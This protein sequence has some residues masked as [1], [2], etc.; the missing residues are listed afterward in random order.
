MSEQKLVVKIEY[1]EHK[2]E[3][4]GDFDAVT[5]Q[6]MNFLFNLSPALS[7]LSKIKL[8]IDFKQLVSDLHGIMKIAKEG[9]LLL[10][11]K[12][13]LT[14]PDLICLYLIGAYVGHK[15]GIFE[16]DSMTVDEISQYTGIKKN[17]VAVRLTELARSRI[18]SA[19]AG[20]R[21]ITSIGIE[22]LKSNILP[23]IRG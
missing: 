16:K 10:V 13:R 21:R 4:S 2:A 19:D 15:L 3:F 1:G 6:V 17:V 22:Y 7:I 14:G 18:V 9:I 11:P 20:E 8:E 12:E 5:R 23:K